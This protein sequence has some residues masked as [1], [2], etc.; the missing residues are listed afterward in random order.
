MQFQDSI[1]IPIEFH[2]IFHGIPKIIGNKSREFQKKSKIDRAVIPT[3]ISP[4]V[5]SPGGNHFAIL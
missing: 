1:G 4:S 5:D 3:S 2:A